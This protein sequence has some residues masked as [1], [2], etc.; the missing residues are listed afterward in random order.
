MMI[1]RRLSRTVTRWLSSLTATSSPSFWPSWPRSRPS[2]SSCP[3]SCWE[4]YYPGGLGSRSLCRSQ[5]T[6]S[7]ISSR[8]IIITISITI[9]NFPSSRKTFTIFPKFIKWSPSTRPLSR[10]SIPPPPRHYPQTPRNVSRLKPRQSQTWD[11][12]PQA[13]RDSAPWRQIHAKLRD[14][15]NLRTLWH[16]LQ[17]TRTFPHL[18]SRNIPI[19][20]NKS[21]IIHTSCIILYFSS[22]TY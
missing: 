19:S 9:I 4:N 7:N 13:P 5:L 17:S 22:A 1:G 21:H 12:P 20:S 15:R 3:P 18:A 14:C 10:Y 16:F 6:T 8:G 2:W 11:A